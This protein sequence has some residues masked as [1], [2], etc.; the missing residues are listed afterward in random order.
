MIDG[1]C[2]EIGAD[3]HIF[4]YIIMIDKDNKNKIVLY[5]EDKSLKEEALLDDDFI[6][7]GTMKS[8]G[9]GKTITLTKVNIK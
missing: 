2:I 6:S 4:T 5:K 1:S 9:E 8:F 7:K 3:K